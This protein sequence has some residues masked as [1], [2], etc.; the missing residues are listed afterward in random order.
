MDGIG[1]N[2]ASS[3]A[4]LNQAERAAKPAPRPEERPAA[5]FRRLAETDEFTVTVVEGPEAIRDPKGN[6][7]EETHEDR[8]EHGLYDS[9]AHTHRGDRNPS[10]D[11]EG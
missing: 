7:Q 11:I 2:L 3:V 6:D 10:L 1:H 5:R 8:A 9:N 4:G